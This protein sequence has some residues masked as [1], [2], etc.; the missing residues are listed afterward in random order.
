MLRLKELRQ[1]AGFRTQQAFAAACALP[2]PHISD[3]ES[4]KIRH[5]TLPVALKL[6]AALNQHLPA[7]ITPAD[8]LPAPTG[9]PGV[10][11]GT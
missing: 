1:A 3:L 4:G 5:P 11:R 2:Q 8:L 9:E 6:V 7:P 10:P